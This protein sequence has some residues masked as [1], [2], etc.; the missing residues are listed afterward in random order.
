MPC[1]WLMLTASATSAY[2]DGLTVMSVVYGVGRM[3]TPSSG[4]KLTYVPTPRAVVGRVA[5]LVR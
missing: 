1:G 2:V 5:G 3:P 4:W